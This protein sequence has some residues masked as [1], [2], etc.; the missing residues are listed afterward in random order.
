LD[1]VVAGF[2][3]SSFPFSCGGCGALVAVLVAGELQLLDSLD[4]FSGGIFAAAM[5]RNFM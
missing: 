2:C 4:V 3:S 5:F 1:G